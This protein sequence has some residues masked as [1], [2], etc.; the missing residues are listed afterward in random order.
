[1][2][3][4][5]KHF[6]VFFYSYYFYILVYLFRLIYRFIKTWIHFILKLLCLCVLN[7]IIRIFNT[8]F[9]ICIQKL[10]V[11]CIQVITSVCIPMV[12]IVLVILTE[13]LKDYYAYAIFFGSKQHIHFERVENQFMHLRGSTCVKFSKNRFFFWHFLHL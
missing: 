5:Y 6:L 12:I 9:Q 1:M 3:T 2:K 8:V 4:H 7:L 11:P 13:N 10:N